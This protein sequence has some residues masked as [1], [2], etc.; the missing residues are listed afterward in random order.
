M[1]CT[2]AHVTIWNLVVDHA[3]RDAH[4]NHCRIFAHLAYHFGCCLWEK[5]SGV[6]TVHKSSSWIKALADLR[7]GTFFLLFQ[8]PHS[9][10]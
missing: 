10:S 8:Q 4:G 7:P 9:I 5:N 2:G 6:S 3:L 1:G